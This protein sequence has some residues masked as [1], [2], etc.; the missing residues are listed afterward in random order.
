MNTV[1]RFPGTLRTVTRFKVPFV[2]FLEFHSPILHISFYSFF[3]SS[4][5]FGFSFFYPRRN[6]WA[7]FVCNSFNFIQLQ[8]GNELL[9]II[10]I[11]ATCFVFIFISCHVFFLRNL[12]NIASWNKPSTPSKSPTPSSLPS[13]VII[14]NI[15][16]MSTH[17]HHRH[18]TV[19]TA[20]FVVIALYTDVVI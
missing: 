15:N 5:Y 16:I 1:K 11:F 19:R 8:E 4:L 13:F 6:Y 18:Y 10:I 7:R 3:L 14:I 20:L 9:K 17:Y 2:S 12:Y